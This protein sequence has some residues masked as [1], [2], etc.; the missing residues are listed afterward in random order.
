MPTSLIGTPAIRPASWHKVMNMLARWHTRVRQR[1][2]IGH[3][4]DRLL[5]DIGIDR[6]AALRESAKP[7]WKA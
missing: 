1:R 7:F 4:D 2:Q 5:R 3:L 6:L